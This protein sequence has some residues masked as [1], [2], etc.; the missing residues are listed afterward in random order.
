[1]LDRSLR[2]LKDRMMAP[3][4]RWAGDAVHPTVIS[5]G[6]FVVGLGCCALLYRGSLVAALVLWVLNRVLDGLDGPVAR[7]QGRESDLGG[8]IDIVLDLVIYALIPISAAAA[9]ASPTDALWVSLAFLL[10]SFYVNV[11]SWMYLAAILEKRGKG[12]SGRGEQTTITF[13][14]GLVEGAETMLLFT[15]IILLP[16]QLT[17]LFWVIA[18]LVGI[19]AVQRLVWAARWLEDAK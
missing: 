12:A 7:Q 10:A 3:L 8:Y 9:A 13:P 19:T 14:T 2:V 15:L 1:M 4:A 5:V 16:G 6:A 18:M 17:A 11:G